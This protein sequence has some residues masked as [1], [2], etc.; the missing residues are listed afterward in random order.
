[1][2]LTDYHN[3]NGMVVCDCG[4]RAFKVGLQ[5]AGGENHI[6]LLE[7][8]DCGKRMAVPFQNGAALESKDD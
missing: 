5:V 6:R 7:C 2:P 3:I 8:D 4:H 1:M